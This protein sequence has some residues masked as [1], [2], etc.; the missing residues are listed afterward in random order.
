MVYKSYQ[1][2]EKLGSSRVNGILQG[3]CY[4]FYKID[5]TNGCIYLKDNEVRFGSRRRELNFKE[6]QDNQG[7]EASVTTNENYKPMYND[8]KKYFEK[9]PNYIIYGEWL[10]CGTLKTYREDAMRQF[11]IF[12]IYDPEKDWYMNYDDYSQ[13][14]NK[15]FPNLKYIP[16]LAKLE[17]PT[18]QDLIPLLDKTGDFLITKGLGEG[19]VIKNYNFIN[20]HGV[21]IW[22]KMLTEDFLNRK[23][24]VKSENKENKEESKT[25]Y[26]VSKLLTDEHISKEYNKLLE[27]KGATWEMSM[28]LELINKV[29]DEFINDNIDII[30]KKFHLPTIDFKKLKQ[31]CTTK[32]R[33]WIEV[34]SNEQF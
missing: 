5:G 23:N 21:T 26:E 33:D 10:V 20:S 24:R 11:Y 31:L 12:D 27:T 34:K 9:H 7:F 16:L 1:H 18:P 28:M 25:E 3:T 8:L 17:Q 22:A 13:E 4:V 32:V 14:L 6:G 15:E 2:V 19:I 29:F 30:L